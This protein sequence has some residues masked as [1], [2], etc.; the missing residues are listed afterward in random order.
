MVS[1][2]CS[3][4]GRSGNRRP[5]S[6]V[7]CHALASMAEWLAARASLC[8]CVTLDNEARGPCRASRHP[9]AQPMHGIARPTSAP[10]RRVSTRPGRRPRRADMMRTGA[11]SAPRC[12]PSNPFARRAAQRIDSTLTTGTPLRLTHTSGSCAATSGCCASRAIARARRAIRASHGEHVTPRPAPLPGRAR[13][14]S[15]RITRPCRPLG[16]RRERDKNATVNPKGRGGCG[17]GP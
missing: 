12:S 13:P 9:S 10:G 6:F 2:L 1:L 3:D 14:R 8:L 4:S 7:P 16:C 17:R 5:A 15:K 11:P